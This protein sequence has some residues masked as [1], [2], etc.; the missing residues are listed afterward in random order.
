MLV[1]LLQPYVVETYGW[2]TAGQFLDGIALTQSVPGPIVTL[3]AFVGYGV[4][5]L[6]GAA[7]ATAGIYIPS[8]T[9]VFQVAPHL[10]RWRQVD[11]VRAVLK[12]VNAVVAG[13][14]LGVALSLVRPA[15]PD[16][17]AGLLLVAALIALFRFGVGAIWLVLAALAVGLGRMLVG[18]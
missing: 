10:E 18:L 2:L 9:A 7:L 13:A 16:P 8:F 3:V 12:G 11:W 15:V 4:A 6:P 5:G 14:I 1:A 17:G